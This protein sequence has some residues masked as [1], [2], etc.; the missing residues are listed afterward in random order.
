MGLPRAGLESTGLVYYIGN[1][2]SGRH[3]IMFDKMFRNFGPKTIAP[4]IAV[5]MGSM[6][7]GCDGAKI[8]IGDTNGV[9]LEELDMAGAA[10][11][12]LVL[13]A[14]DSV[15]LTKGKK[16]SIDVEGDDD[17][18]EGLRFSLD[19]GTLGISRENGMGWR[20]EKATIR[21]T[22]PSP[23][24]ITMA[25]SGSVAAQDMASEASITIAGS[26]RVDVASLKA[27]ALTIAVMGS[28]QV[29]V[30]GTAK[31]LDLS[32]A[33]S[34][35]AELDELNAETAEISIAGS[36]SGAFASDGE[37]TANIVGS[38]DVTVFGRATC[39][40]SSVGSGSLTCKPLDN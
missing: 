4:I 26:G 29:G 1:T 37:V 28:G 21:V 25:G 32:I 8:N 23:S 11:E 33:G 38:G 19:D 31:T 27:D 10:P 34:G 15:V 22:M 16:L 9:P 5:A 13:A 3:R 35:R 6:A 7:S 39:E 24:A 30:A 14:P 12:S 36:G 18:K 2:Q 20:G 17:S 40:I